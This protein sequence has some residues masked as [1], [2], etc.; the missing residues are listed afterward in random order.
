MSSRS[1]QCLLEDMQEAI[2]RILRYVEGLDADEFIADEKTSDAVVRNLEI[3]GEAA[4]RLPDEFCARHTEIEWR[5]IIG[6]R[7]RIVHDYFGVDLALVWQIATTN[8]PQLAEQLSRVAGKSG[9]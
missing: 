7:H 4:N 6:L 3:I 5:K 8:I 9:E 1:P 2:G